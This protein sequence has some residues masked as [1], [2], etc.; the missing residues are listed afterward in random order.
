MLAC[1]IYVA[2]VLAIGAGPML[3][4]VL[5]ETDLSMED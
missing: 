4:A 3:F 5:A 1:L 2:L